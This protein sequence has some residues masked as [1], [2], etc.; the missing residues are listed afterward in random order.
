MRKIDESKYEVL[1]RVLDEYR[2]KEG[3][4]PN[5]GEISELAG[6]SRA[7]AFRYLSVMRDN[8]MIEMDGRRNIRTRKFMKTRG[9]SVMT[10]VIG[11]I[12]CGTPILAEQNIEC[13][14]PMPREIVGQGDF[15]ILRAN[16][17][18]MK[19]AG[20]TNGDLVLIRRQNTAESGQIIVALVNDEAATLKYYKP[21]KKAKT[22]DLIP[23]NADFS[24]RT[25]DL[26]KE[27]LEI[28]G[29]A[30]QVIKSLEDQILN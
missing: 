3:G 15:F 12:A 4:T 8:G 24:T 19:D 20:I 16:G 27:S 6:M 11:E 7:T 18:S 1:E 10:P 21:N 30:V 26:K 23:A 25:I 14:I 5:I 22:V 17:N 13:F 9:A 28:Q 29:V 2:E